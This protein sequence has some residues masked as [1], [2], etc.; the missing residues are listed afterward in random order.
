MVFQ[1]GRH[2]QLRTMIRGRRC[3]GLIQLSITQWLGRNISMCN[4]IFVPQRIL[5]D[6]SGPN[7]LNSMP[8][9]RFAVLQVK[10]EMHLMKVSPLPRIKGRTEIKAFQISLPFSAPTVG[11][12]VRGS[13]SSSP[14]SSFAKSNIQFNINH[15]FTSYCIRRFKV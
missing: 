15:C 5:K 8:T 13:G 11:Q 1:E 4:I 10:Q 6:T 3:L 7:A 14:V 9:L 12:C 2:Y